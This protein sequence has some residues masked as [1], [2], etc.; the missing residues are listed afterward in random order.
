MYTFDSKL[1]C[2]SAAVPRLPKHAP[3]TVSSIKHSQQPN[4]RS[5]VR[6]HTDSKAADTAQSV[7][8]K[9]FTLDNNIV[10]NTSQYSHNNQEGKN[11][12][13]HELTHV[14]QENG[15]DNL[16]LKRA[17]TS[18]PFRNIGMLNSWGIHCVYE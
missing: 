2:S 1:K 13:A 8:A 9:A 4:I 11:L 15:W 14:V 18:F 6:I 16:G 7:Q 5:S 17:S 12:L 3:Y 10:F